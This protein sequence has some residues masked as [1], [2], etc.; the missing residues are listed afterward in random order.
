MK[1]IIL[2]S[3]LLAVGCGKKPGSYDVQTKA[4]AEEASENVLEQADA[5]WPQ[6]G[7]K[8]KLGEALDLYEK[9]FASNPTDKYA[10]GRLVRGWYFMGDVH[11]SEKAAKMDAWDKAVAFGD[12]CL[13][14]NA[15]YKA[16]LEKSGSKG[17]AIKM[18]TK[19]DVPCIYWSASS[20][21]KWAK[22]NGILQS[23][24]HKSTFVGFM[25][26]V[27]ALQ[28]DY[29]YGAP[30]RYWGAYY[31]VLPGFA[32]RD[33]DRSKE[34]FDKSIG[35]APEYLGTYLL[36]ADNWARNSQNVE[37]FDQAVQYVLASD[38]EALPADLL[39]ENQAELVKAKQ[40]WDNRAGI[41]PDPAEPKP[42]VNQPPKKEEA[43]APVEETLIP[44]EEAAETTD[45]PVDDATAP[46]EEIPTETPENTPAPE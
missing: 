10:L 38:P 14:L 45:A 31:A 46:T 25:E 3:L 17:E 40:L 7:D 12:T 21:G 23:L 1:P 43:P 16:T 4:V 44:T 5:L 41:F 26:Q 34:N 6:R 37:E 8:T 19:D 11:E 9:A 18:S 39:P 13:A 29:F 36:L 2:S 20:L 35:I 28:P 15:D 42:L 32:G 30:Y 27:E 24:K 22:L 33:L